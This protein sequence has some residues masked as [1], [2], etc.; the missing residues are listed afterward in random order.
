VLSYTVAQRT[1]EL[2][3][4]AALGARRS[5]L[6]ALVLWQ[7]LSVAFGG[8]AAGLVASLWATRYLGTLLYGVSAGDWFTYLAVSVVLVVVAA[9][10][11]L[12]PARR[13]AALDP[14]RAL[15]S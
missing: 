1:R 3:L 5:D 10:A 7:G 12:V 14:L 15:R 6:I 13:A 4:R 9:M 11:C 8:I 2:G